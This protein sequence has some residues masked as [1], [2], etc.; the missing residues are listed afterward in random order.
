MEIRY[1]LCSLSVT[2][3]NMP[4]YPLMTIQLLKWRKRDA[5]TE[6]S[7]IFLFSGI[8][9]GG[10]TDSRSCFDYSSTLSRSPTFFIHSSTLSI[11]LFPDGDSFLGGS[12]SISLRDVWKIQGI[13]GI[14]Q[15]GGIFWVWVGICLWTI[16]ECEGLRNERGD[17]L[18]GFWGVKMFCVL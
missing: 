4:V 6:D 12:I 1:E 15:L 11:F 3:K 7:C 8:S 18:Y 17:W 2:L 16:M 5:S 14:Q 9:T 10:A 13:C